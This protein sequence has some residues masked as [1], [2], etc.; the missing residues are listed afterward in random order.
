[1]YQWSQRN[2][3]IL[4]HI[5][6]RKDLFLSCL[7]LMRERMRR[8]F[9]KFPLRICVH[10]VSISDGKVVEAGKEK[11]GGGGSVV[12]M[13]GGVGAARRICAAV[14]PCVYKEDT[15][16][17]DFVTSEVCVAH[18]RGSMFRFG[19]KFRGGKD[20]DANVITHTGCSC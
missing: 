14:I 17:N 13:G 20:L 7:G 1:M 6:I 12:G 9:R 2:L 10:N 5:Y 8:D 3:Q 19:P 4:R 11:G 15:I 18:R 16:G